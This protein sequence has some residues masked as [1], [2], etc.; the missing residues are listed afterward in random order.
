VISSHGKLISRRT[1][2]LAIIIIS[3]IL[4]Y[5]VILPICWV[6]S[7]ANSGSSR[8]A[9]FDFCGHD[10]ILPNFVLSISLVLA[11]LSLLL[12]P[13]SLFFDWRRWKKTNSSQ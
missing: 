9:F 3:P 6:W 12:A 1:K 13:I 11:I 4:V 7:L 5:L 2:Q 10:G 8:G